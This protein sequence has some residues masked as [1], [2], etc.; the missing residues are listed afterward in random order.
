[1]R[2]WVKATPVS[3][4]R[5]GEGPGQILSSR[6]YASGDAGKVIS[7]NVSSPRRTEFQPRQR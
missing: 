1:M 2:K 3:R 5:L 4:S 6:R 7:L